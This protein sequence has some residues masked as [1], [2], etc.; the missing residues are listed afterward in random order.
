M[1]YRFETDDE[2]EAKRLIKARDMALVLWDIAHN[3]PTEPEA[4][5]GYFLQRIDEY[6][7]NIDELIN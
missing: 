1:K 4:V 6:N 2:M 5:Y 3:C 7:I